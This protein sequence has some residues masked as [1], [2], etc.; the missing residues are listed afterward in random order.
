MDWKK[1]KKILII[2]LLVANAILFCYSNYN[3]FRLRNESTRIDFVREVSDLL[4]EK[5]ISLDTNIPR[6]SKKLPSVLVSFET[7][8]E[9]DI[10]DRYFRG[11][12]KVARPSTDLAE[13]SLGDEYVNLLNGR[14]V[15][16]ENRNKK[17]KYKL[18]SLEEA[19]NIAQKFLLDKKYD[20]RDIYLSYY[21][22][23][24]DKYILNYTKIFDS[25]P[26]ESSYTN[27]VIDARGVMS[28]DR[29][30][31]DVLNKSEQKIHLAPAGRTLLSLLNKT[32]Y[33]NKTI[34][35][36][37]P[38]FYFNPED[39]GYIEDITRA[40]NGRAIPAWKVKFTDGEYTVLSNY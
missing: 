16:Y 6:R 35:K 23:D 4:A 7:S 32:E 2:A 38:C 5:N 12:G 15:F 18:D 36:I 25:L 31:L 11:K 37:S 22:V 10:N 14:R 29:L 1:I 8:S 9:E 13:I 21:Q 27:F 3:N 28:M 34:E 39:Q 24:G 17:N 26:V 33:Y 20:T 40:V 30:W 19:Q